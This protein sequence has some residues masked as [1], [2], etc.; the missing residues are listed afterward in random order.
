MFSRST[1]ATDRTPAAGGI[2]EL[3]SVSRLGDMAQPSGPGQPIPLNG[4]TMPSTASTKGLSI[5]GPD[6]IISGAGLRIVSA[7]TLQVDGH[8]QGDVQGAQVVIGESGRIDGVV[9]AE[10]VIVRG[11]VHGEI[12]GRDVLLDTKSQVEG[13]VNH[14]RLTIAQGALFEGRS[15]RMSSTNAV[16][17]DAAE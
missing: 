15:R 11:K 1:P 9:A 5:I 16:Q 6:L 8:I 17:L 12:R 13:D 3:K 14:H 2:P 4:V 7:G 10:H